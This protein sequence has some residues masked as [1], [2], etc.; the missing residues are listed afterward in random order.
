MEDLGNGHDDAIARAGSSLTSP[1]TNGESRTMPPS[2]ASMGELAPGSTTT[3]NVAQLAEVERGEDGG[4]ARDEDDASSGSDEDIVVED[5]PAAMEAVG[6]G[7]E[8][9]PYLD[10]AS[11]PRPKEY[12]HGDGN[13][14]IYSF[15]EQPP[16]TP[17]GEVKVVKKF[18]YH[19]LTVYPED[20]TALCMDVE[21]DQTDKYCTLSVIANDVVIVKK[22]FAEH[23]AGGA[24]LKPFYSSIVRVC[25]CPLHNKM[26]MASLIMDAARSTIPLPSLSA[27]VDSH[28]GEAAAAV[29]SAAAAVD[30]AFSSPTK[31][32]EADAPLRRGWRVVAE[33]GDGFIRFFHVMRTSECYCD[34]PVL[35]TT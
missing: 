4:T 8:E 30:D 16:T 29:A 20:T 15:I 25:V 19:S 28:V 13:E 24:T 18:V 32:T 9:S 34:F 35:F 17:N 10:P 31:G 23:F 27:A 11:L 7:T 33:N 6:D 5:D 3:T 22:S 26:V 2:V 21:C 12:A 1:P 14:L